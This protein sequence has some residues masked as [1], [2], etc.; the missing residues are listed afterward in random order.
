MPRVPNVMPCRD[1]SSTVARRNLSE[2][3][4]AAKYTLYSLLKYRYPDKVK[5]RRKYCVYI[6]LDV[7]GLQYITR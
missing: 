2:A 1:P 6:L 7:C 5:M 3:A 4:L